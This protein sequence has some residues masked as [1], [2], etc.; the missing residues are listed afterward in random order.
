MLDQLRSR[1][2][3]I[4]AL[5]EKPPHTENTVF[6]QLHLPVKSP[7]HPNWT[8]HAVVKDWGIGLLGHTFYKIQYLNLNQKPNTQNILNGFQGH[9]CLGSLET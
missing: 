7:P 8:L 6:L 5:T 9:Q 4:R 1:N 2:Q 3:G